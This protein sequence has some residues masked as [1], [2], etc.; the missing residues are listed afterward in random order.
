M[1]AGDF[2]VRYK[3]LLNRQPENH[4]VLVSER[5][6]FGKVRIGGKWKRSTKHRLIGTS[7]KKSAKSLTDQIGLVL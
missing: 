1:I 4:N 5:S 2:I 6:P 3:E 7:F